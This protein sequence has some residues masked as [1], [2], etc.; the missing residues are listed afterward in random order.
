MNQHRKVNQM[1]IP[2]H[3][4]TR[5]RVVQVDGGRG[6]GKPGA[7]EPRCGSTAGGEHRP[8]VNLDAV[9]RWGMDRG[10]HIWTRR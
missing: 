1:K 6:G 9:K 4:N 8:A 3:F 5:V 10:Q 2:R 7:P